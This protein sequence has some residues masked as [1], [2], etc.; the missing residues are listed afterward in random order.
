MKGHVLVQQKNNGRYLACAWL[1]VRKWE[2]VA[3]L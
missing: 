2:V 3:W 1:C